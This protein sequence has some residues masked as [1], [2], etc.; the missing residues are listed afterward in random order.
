MRLGLDAQERISDPPTEQ[1]V[2]DLAMAFKCAFLGFVY[3]NYLRIQSSPKAELTTAAEGTVK[4]IGETFF[5]Q[6]PPDACLKAPISEQPP[7]ASKQSLAEG[8]V[9]IAETSSSLRRFWNSLT[10]ALRG[11]ALV[12]SAKDSNV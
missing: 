4:A 12:G 1:F 2:S 3:L 7:S 10:S 9:A 5:D 11:L 6:I 8:M